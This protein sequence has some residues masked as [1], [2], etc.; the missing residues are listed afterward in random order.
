MIQGYFPSVASIGRNTVY[1][2][3]RNG[4]CNV[5]F[6][7]HETLENMFSFLKATNIKIGRARK[8]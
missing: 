3:N 7:Q 8:D 1:F 2:E 4:N 5:K 6:E